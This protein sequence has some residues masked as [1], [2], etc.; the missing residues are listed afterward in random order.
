MIVAAWCLFIFFGWMLYLV[1]SEDGKGLER[2]TQNELEALNV[3]IRTDD[4]QRRHT[5]MLDRE[6]DKKKWRRA[7]LDAKELNQRRKFRLFWDGDINS[8]VR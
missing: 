4:Q 1:I 3:Q 8:S 5:W 7:W 6:E 2:V